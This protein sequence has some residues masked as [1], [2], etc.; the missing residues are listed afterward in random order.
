M[1]INKQGE[2]SGTSCQRKEVSKVAEIPHVILF[3]HDNFCGAHVHVF[4]AVDNL[5]N[6]GFR[7]VTSSIVVLSGTWAFYRDWNYGYAYRTLG[8]GLY[9]KVDVP[10]IWIVNDSLSSLRPVSSVSAALRAEI[11]RNSKEIASA[12]A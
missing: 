1:T 8:P 3:E 2:Q 5:E 6:M 9:P 7:D 12:K 11:D 10:G 4:Q